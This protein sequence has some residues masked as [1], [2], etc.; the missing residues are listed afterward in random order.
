MSNLVPRVPSHPL[1]YR[2]SREVARAIAYHIDRAA[3]GAASVQADAYIV[4]QALHVVADF[5]ETEARLIA[6]T[7]LAEPRL[8]VI[9]DAGT[10]RIANTVEGY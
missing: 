2:P 5:T 1:V 3:V 10:A 9:A 7:P 4:N 8:R 6:R